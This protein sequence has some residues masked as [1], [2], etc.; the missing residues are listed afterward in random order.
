MGSRVAGVFLMLQVLLMARTY[1]LYAQTK[2]RQTI[3][4]GRVT[5]YEA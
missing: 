4:I 3:T 5:V 2:V 1:P